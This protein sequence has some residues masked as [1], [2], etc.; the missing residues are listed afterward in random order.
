MIVVA[1]Q[2]VLAA[3]L[4]DE[5]GA[6][7]RGIFLAD[8]AARGGRKGLLAIVTRDGRHAGLVQRVAGLAIFGPLEAGAA[9]LD[10][11]DDT[12]EVRVGEREP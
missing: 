12:V 4:V 9:T 2:P 10:R 6:A 1:R 3:Q 11:L 7:G 5:L 8:A